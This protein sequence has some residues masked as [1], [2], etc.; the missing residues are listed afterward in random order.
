MFCKH[1]TNNSSTCSNVQKV[2]LEFLKFDM[3]YSDDCVGDKLNT[4]DGTSDR[5]RLLRTD[6]GWDLPTD[7]VSTGN[8]LF[9]KFVTDRSEIG[10]GFLVRY[11][12]ESG[13]DSGTDYEYTEDGNTD[14]GTDYGYT[15]DST[16]SGKYNIIMPDE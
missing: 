1:K 5:A 2:R 14:S 9:V 12:T 8:S 6:C 7:I 4:Y 11:T 3:E 10:M 16:G 15:D 13:G